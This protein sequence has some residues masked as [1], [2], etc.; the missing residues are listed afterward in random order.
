MLA[1]ESLIIGSKLAVRALA[2]CAVGFRLPLVYMKIPSTSDHPHF[3]M[4]VTIQ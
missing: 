1:F 3:S 2:T 4:H